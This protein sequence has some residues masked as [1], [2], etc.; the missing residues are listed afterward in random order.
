MG[1]RTLPRRGTDDAKRT[2][3][4]RAGRRPGPG[5]ARVAVDAARRSPKKGEEVKRMGLTPKREA[6]VAAYAG[7]ASAAALAAG[8]S[9]KTAHVIG[10][11]LL[12]KPEIQEAIQTRMGER[13]NPLVA[14]REE[15]QSFWSSVMRDRESDPKDRLRASEL[16]GKSEGDFLDRIENRTLEAPSIVVNFIPDGGSFNEGKREEL[17]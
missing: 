3:H 11:E 1:V 8:Y 5:L 15:R 6:F 14:N 16:L 7:N 10:H 12:K 4:R 13:L 2:R 17:E 9:P